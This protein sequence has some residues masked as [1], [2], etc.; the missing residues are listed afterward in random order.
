MNIF[1]LMGA[2][3]ALAVMTGT[4]FAGT[5]IEAHDSKQIAETERAKSLLEQDYL[6]GDWGGAR[7]K[8]ADQGVT[9]GATY[10]GETMGNVSGGVDQTAVYA[11]RLQLDMTLDFE[12]LAGLKGS[13][14]YVSAYEIH[15]QDLSAGSIRNLMT[16]SNIE[17]YDTFRLFDLWYQQELFDGKV[18]LRFGQLAADDEFFISDYSSVF[19]NGTFGWPALMGANLPSGG[20]GY[21]L[22]TPAVRLAVKPTDALTL[23]AALFDGDA[24]DSPGAD[25]PQKRNS[26]G[27]RVDFNQG[28]LAIFEAAYKINQEKGLPGSYK[29]GTFV[30]FFHTSD[31][32]TDDTG[33]SLADPAT[34]GQAKQHANNWGVYFIADQMIWGEPGTNHREVDSEVRSAANSPKTTECCF[35]QGLGAFWRIGGMPEDRNTISFY[36]DGGLSYTGLIPGR[37]SDIFAL[38]V[39]Y[40]QISE[41]LRNLDRET[42]NFNGTNAPVRDYEIAFEA[43]YQIVLAP[44]WTVQPDVQYIIHPGGHTADP[45]DPNGTAA[46]KDAV[47]LGLR[48]SVT[49]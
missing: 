6:T 49:F 32:S 29:L 1:R 10:I 42:N 43:T 8:L 38:G 27:T 47:V 40:A 33:N 21:P 15:G 36:T 17:A 28:A 41:D 13:S 34:S 20:P 14:F 37:D 44:W 25:N 11:G 23:Q 12:K 4:T 24:G 16:V 3:L 9:F 30:N 18:S 45:T 5:G 2:T 26:S 19:I 46:I 48:T 35:Q 39:A 22:A 7:T 31:V